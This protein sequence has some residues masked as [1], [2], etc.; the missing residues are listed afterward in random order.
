MNPLQLLL[1]FYG[2]DVDEHPALRAQQREA[3]RSALPRL[4]RRLHATAESWSGWESRGVQEEL[5][6]AGNALVTS[7]AHRLQSKLRGD[8]HR[9]DH[10]GVHAALGGHQP[11]RLQ[12]RAMFSEVPNLWCLLEDI[13]KASG[14]DGDD[15]ADVVVEAMA[16]LLATGASHAPGA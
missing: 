2:D 9:G 6:R 5:L 1:S 16:I 3:R 7:E 15:P 11:T 13:V 10:F 12:K 4:V 14:S 8:G